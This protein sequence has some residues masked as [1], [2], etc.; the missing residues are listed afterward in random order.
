MA[1]QIGDKVKFLN[2]EG[3][4][5]ITQ[6]IDKDT[7]MV[8]SDIDDFEIPVLIKELVVLD[9]EKDVDFE[10]D[11]SVLTKM[12]SFQKEID[13]F[14]FAHKEGKI[15]C[16]LSNGKN[17]TLLFGVFEQK[18]EG[19]FGLF[20]GMLQPYSLQE[21]GNYSLK[22][23]EGI[24]KWKV[25]GF[26][27]EKNPDKIT[28]PLNCAVKV[29]PKKLFKEGNKEFIEELGLEAIVINLEEPEDKVALKAEDLFA[30][31][32]AMSQST[33]VKRAERK[34]TKELLEVDLHI[35]ELLETTK[36]MSNGDML[37]YQLDTFRKVLD[38][39]KKYKG[40]RI[41]FI[42]GVGNGVLKQRIRHELQKYPR[43]IVQ[44]ASFQEYGWGATMVIIK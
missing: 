16:Y 30:D 5:K 26:Y 13:G 36:G 19:N 25:Q 9:K 17:S 28:A 40:K 33:E 22:E 38:T 39:N 32:T 11:K 41:V 14:L 24:I 10:L 21:I 2:E 27:F 7:V 4:G 20:S 44:D 42:H 12:R 8:L 1:L 34:D 31:G 23:F 37:E 6:L 18:K 43:Y 35:N 29:H 15:T 3:G